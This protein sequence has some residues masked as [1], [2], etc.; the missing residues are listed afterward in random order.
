[1][2][3]K[4]FT[5][6]WAQESEWQKRRLSSASAAAS[7]LQLARSQ[8]SIHLFD[9]EGV[10][11]EEFY[12]RYGAALAHRHDGF[13]EKNALLASSR[14]ETSAFV[15]SP[16]DDPPV[17]HLSDLLDDDKEEFHPLTQYGRREI[18]QPI[19]D[20]HYRA[21]TMSY[22]S[23]DDDDDEEDLDM[24]DDDDEESEDEEF[25]Y[26]TSASPR[27]SMGTSLAQIKN[28]FVSFPRFVEDPQQGKRAGI[29]DFG[30]I[31]FD[32][33]DPEDAHEAADIL[34][35]YEAQTEAEAQIDSDEGANLCDYYDDDDD[36]NDNVN[37]SN[38]SREL[39]R[40]I[41]EAEFEWKVR[42]PVP[43]APKWKDRVKY[44]CAGRCVPKER[45][46]PTDF[47]SGRSKLRQVTSVAD[48]DAEEAYW[49]AIEA[50]FVDWAVRQDEAMMDQSFQRVSL[51][52]I[53]ID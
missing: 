26:D 12:D 11:Q 2:K 22:F 9:P 44:F 20:D 38:D 47:L 31:G 13:D 27:N 46:G 4:S 49:R 8:P 37:D 19:A 21:S 41:E 15:I 45:L 14:Q 17:S 34:N 7:A 30:S 6:L 51:Q 29:A 25:P 23:D 48:L 39:L 35:I 53:M 43:P 16:F 3:R 36:D 1:M 32:D 24:T 18:A 33:M 40:A 50:D 28:G 10:E 52:E 5:D 42:N